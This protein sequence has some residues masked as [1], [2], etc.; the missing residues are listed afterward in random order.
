VLVL[1]ARASLIRCLVTHGVM[2]TVIQH[3]YGLGGA[4][5]LVVA[6]V[7]G[8]VVAWVV[9]GEGGELMGTLGGKCCSYFRR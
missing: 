4:M 5:V 6:L 3:R 1:A 9:V 7:V 2:A 8:S